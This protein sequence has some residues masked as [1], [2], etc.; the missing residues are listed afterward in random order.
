MSGYRV[1]ISKYRQIFKDEF[2]ILPS[3]IVYKMLSNQVAISV[4]MLKSE[5]AIVERAFIFWCN[6]NC[7]GLFR[8][9]DDGGF[10]TFFFEEETDMCGFKQ[11]F[12]GCK[13]DDF[14]DH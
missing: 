6:E 14:K 13:L 11:R 7:N 3:E 2:E 12:E 4:P 9:W 8:I 1:Q 10:K 5:E